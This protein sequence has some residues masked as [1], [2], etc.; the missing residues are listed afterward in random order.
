MLM[1]H[2]YKCGED[3]IT[4]LRTS[5]E[6]HIY[7]KKRLHK[8]PSYSRIYA[9]FGADMDIDNSSIGNKK[10][11]IFKQNP[12]LNGYHILSELEDVLKSGYYKSPLGYKYVDRFVNEVTIIENK[13]AFYFKNTKKVIIITEK[14]NENFRNDNS[15]TLCGKKMN[16]IKLE[17]IVV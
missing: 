17:N 10:T 6:S 7:W 1:L 16:L 15:R 8:N 12:V 9:D 2:E 14:D 4:T 5:P 3:D 13:M 11:K